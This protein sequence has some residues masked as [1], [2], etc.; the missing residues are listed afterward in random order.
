[1]KKLTL[2]FAFFFGL[3]SNAIAQDKLNFTFNTDS[4]AVD[5][6]CQN[7]EWIKGS[8]VLNDSLYFR[9]IS[10]LIQKVNKSLNKSQTTLFTKLN[11]LWQ[12]ILMNLTQEHGFQVAYECSE[13]YLLQFNV[14]IF[15]F[16]TKQNWP[17]CIYETDKDLGLFLYYNKPCNIDSSLLIKCKNDDNINMCMQK[18]LCDEIS[19]FVTEQNQQSATK[20]M[21]ELLNLTN[22]FIKSIESNPDKQQE[23]IVRFYNFYYLSILYSYD[24]ISLFVKTSTE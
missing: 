16:V 4:D 8:F 2:I 12:N 17:E 23:Y 1:M 7:F 10:C 3:Y 14:R 5:K 13:E 6:Q 20:N 18:I 9:A 21:S 11:N 15:N 19:Q 24:T 22:Q